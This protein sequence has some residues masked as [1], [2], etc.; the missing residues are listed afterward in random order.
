MRIDIIKPELYTKAIKPDRK[1]NS[2]RVTPPVV[3]TGNSKIFPPL[4]YFVNF[5]GYDEDKAFIVSTKKALDN[6]MQSVINYYGENN[7]E[8]E[9]ALQIL[10]DNDIKEYNKVINSENK[11]KLYEK[12]F[13]AFNQITLN[14]IKDVQYGEA[15]FSSYWCDNSYIGGKKT[16]DIINKT[17]NTNPKQNINDTLKHLDFEESNKLRQNLII[18]WFK[19]ENVLLNNSA[20]MVHNDNKRLYVILEKRIGKYETRRFLKQQES[21]Y[22][23]EF[24]KTTIDKILDNKNSNEQK[25]EAVSEVLG[26]L[27]NQLKIEDAAGMK[28]HLKTISKVQQHL[29]QGIGKESAE[30]VE[31]DF[32]ALYGIVVSDWQKNSLPVLI[33][34]S[35][36]RAIYVNDA[37]KKT[38]LMMT[39][40]GYSELSPE[41]KFFVAKYYNENDNE[42]KN[43]MLKQIIEDRD[44]L[45]PSVII[46]TISLKI[47]SDRQ[48]Y[49]NQ[50]DTFCDYL[51]DRQAN[52]DLPEPEV[53][54]PHRKDSFSFIDTYLFELNKLDDYSGKSTKD[55]LNY[56]SNLTEDELVLANK[57][58]KQQWDENELQYLLETEVRKQAKYTSINTKMYEELQ[59]INVNLGD[60]KVKIDNV[61][62]TLKDLIDNKYILKDETEIQKAVQNSSTVIADAERRYYMQTP[63]EQAQTDLKIRES[64]PVVIDNLIQKT[65]DKDIIEKLT[66]IK[67]KCK[68]PK[69]KANEIFGMLKTIALGRAMGFGMNKG[70]NKIG[71]LFQG[72]TMHL[73]QPMIDV[74]QDANV[75]DIATQMLQ[76][77]GTGAAVHATTGGHL[78]GLLGAIPPVDPGTA[79]IIIAITAVAGYT[80]LGAKAATKLE[81]GQ[82]ELYVE[83]SG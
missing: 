36:Y 71:N 58:I 62:F 81:R 7:Y 51:K 40:P 60:I 50:L 8:F 35:L 53:S 4:G 29:K 47:E 78:S 10:H 67:T 5:Q 34:R 9:D 43:N 37:E 16:S 52:P 68:E 32:K 69:T 28:S 2:A 42:L 74:N 21:Y 3:N 13:D 66:F 44:I 73:H 24:N 70:Y 30:Y 61:S 64:M 23:R 1:T 15:Q 26:Y 41:Q 56:L 57:K 65:D 25:L 49:F 59:K 54:I 20:D 63:Q 46:D 75:S 27:E 12:E 45:D 39:I 38:P 33:N 77:A 11:F 14:S 19:N 22:T 76:G 18:E 55:K 17:I 79:A 48:K 83:F 80:V 72:Q 82:R 31:D 6:T